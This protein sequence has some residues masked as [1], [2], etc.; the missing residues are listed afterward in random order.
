MKI[1]IRNN[2]QGF[3]LPELIV[4]MAMFAILIGLVTINL[5]GA[6]GST[7]INTT[8][9]TLTADIKQQ[10]TKA[11]VGETEGS[12][13]ANSYGIHFETSDYILFRGT[14]YTSGDTSNL[15]IDI[16][17]ATITSTTIPNNQIIFDQGD[18]KIP[19]LTNN[20]GSITLKTPAGQQ[21]IVTLNSY[22]AIISIE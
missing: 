19:G 9:D 15:T 8:I 2:S 1:S 17:G 22:G 7:N 13:S 21:K 18:G 14:S 3:T 20:Q 4:G 10:Q 5:T 12:T 16:K 6:Q 11:M